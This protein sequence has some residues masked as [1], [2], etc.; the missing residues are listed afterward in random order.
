MYLMVQ[1]DKNHPT[2]PPLPPKYYFQNKSHRNYMFYELHLY[3]LPWAQISALRPFTVTL[4]ISTCKENKRAEL[5][6][7]I[8][9]L[10][11]F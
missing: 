3:G 8:R 5:K 10:V 1:G 7:S 6:L 9:L 11:G 2:P 4:A